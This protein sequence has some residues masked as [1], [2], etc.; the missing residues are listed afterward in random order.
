MKISAS[1]NWR[2]DL[3]RSKYFWVSIYIY[4]WTYRRVVPLDIL[5]SF[6]CRCGGCTS[7]RRYRS[8]AASCRWLRLGTSCCPEVKQKRTLTKR[9]FPIKSIHGRNPTNNFKV[10]RFLFEIFIHY[11]GTKQNRKT[12]RTKINFKNALEVRKKSLGLMV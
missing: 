5:K 8:C 10:L 9:N 11:V 12:I 4:V 2:Y 6:V 3:G 1:N 7:F